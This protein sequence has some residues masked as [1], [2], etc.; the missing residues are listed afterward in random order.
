MKDLFLY[1]KNLNRISLKK[2]DNLFYIF[3]LFLFAFNKICNVFGKL[4]R[5][6]LTQIN[7]RT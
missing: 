6:R 7:D 2:E 4:T 1:K 3:Y 5:K